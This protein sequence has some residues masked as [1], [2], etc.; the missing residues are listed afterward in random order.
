MVTNH[1]ICIRNGTKRGGNNHQE[2]VYL[3]QISMTESSRV[4]D[5]LTEISHHATLI[6]ALL[7][8]RVTLLVTKVTLLVTMV[9]IKTG[10]GITHIFIILPLF[11]G[12]GIE[13]EV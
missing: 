12:E 10:K 1:Q 5:C 6:T 8:T 2:S 9:T 13:G 7:V 11:T 3:V 4:K